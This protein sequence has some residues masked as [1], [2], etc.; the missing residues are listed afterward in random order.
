MSK[1]RKF[2][3]FFT[4]PEGLD[5]ET[6]TFT[7]EQSSKKYM[8]PIGIAEDLSRVPQG[9]NAPTILMSAEPVLDISFADRLNGKILTILEASIANQDQLKAIKEL[10]RNTIYSTLHETNENLYRSTPATHY[11][12][13]LEQPQ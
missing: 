5:S 12:I 11:K 6:V 8:K 9:N 3:V 13:E 7:Y 10:T 4:D 1:E 2:A